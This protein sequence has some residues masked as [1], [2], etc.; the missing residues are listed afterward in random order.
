MIGLNFAFWLQCSYNDPPQYRLRVDDIRVF[1]D[2]TE[3]TVELVAIVSNAAAQ[4][5]LDREGHGRPGVASV[6]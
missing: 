5:W 6:R 3:A 2:I 4:D 1:H